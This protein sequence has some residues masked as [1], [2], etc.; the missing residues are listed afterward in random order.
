[1]LAAFNDYQEMVT[2][3]LPDLA[4]EA[5]CTTG[6]Q[7]LGL[8]SLKVILAP[9]GPS[10]LARD[11]CAV[12]VSRSAPGI[13]SASAPVA[14]TSFAEVSVCD[15]TPSRLARESGHPGHKAPKTALDPRFRAW[16]CTHLVV[17]AKL[18]L[19]KAGSGERGP[20]PAPGKEQGGD[21]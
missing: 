14:G 7:N 19:A 4:G 1:V 11:I 6:E 8:S 9:V 10:R 3:E 2:R 20:R 5:N 17:P 21:R 12:R 18:V 13:A 15:S 16:V